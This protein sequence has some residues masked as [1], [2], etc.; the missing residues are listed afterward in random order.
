MT[1]RSWLG[2]QVQTSTR[3]AK[4][5]FVSYWSSGGTEGAPGTSEGAPPE[6]A[7][8]MAIESTSVRTL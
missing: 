6:H 5:P 1:T 2:V 8:A 3:Y 7:L 4:P